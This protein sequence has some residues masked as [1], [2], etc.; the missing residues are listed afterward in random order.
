VDLN[1]P[2]D[3]RTRGCEIYCTV[4]QTAYA[5]STSDAPFARALFVALT[6]Q[7]VA[8]LKAE[9]KTRMSEAFARLPF[10]TVVV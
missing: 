5:V 7:P 9:L 2:L 3:N 10:G 6:L 1:Q 8:P 4:A